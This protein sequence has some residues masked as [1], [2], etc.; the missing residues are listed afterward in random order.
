M[1]HELRDLSISLSDER[2]R[3]KMRQTKLASDMRGLVR[4]RS[5]K[6]KQA[7]QKL[8]PDHS[9]TTVKRVRQYVPQFPLPT[10]PSFL[11]WEVIKPTVS[12]DMLRMQ[13]GSFLDQSDGWKHINTGWAMEVYNH[14]EAIREQQ[15][16]TAPGLVRQIEDIDAR[17][18][19]IETFM[20]DGEQRLSPQTKAKMADALQSFH[21]RGLSTLQ[22]PAQSYA[23]SS[24]PDYQRPSDG[25]DLAG[26][27]FWWMVLSPES[28]F[29]H[30]NTVSE[31]PANNAGDT[32]S[33]NEGPT[34][35]SDSGDTETTLAHH[36][37]LGSQSFS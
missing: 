34:E 5:E 20:K 12:L 19:A 15:T 21:G 31:S 13:L 14:D 1:Q 24:R 9:T 35:H 2:R 18:E 17:I 33:S 23:Q 6:A 11:F 29:H 10:I 32:G 36:E 27:W 7:L 25:I 37:S 8:L 22:V 3:L 4:M 30:H 28:E 26:L 16:V